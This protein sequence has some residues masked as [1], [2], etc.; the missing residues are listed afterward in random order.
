MCQP[1]FQ[2][3]FRDPI[4]LDALQV[5][6]TRALVLIDTQGQ[7]W[8]LSPTGVSPDHTE[9]A[10]NFEQMVPR[11]TYSI[12][13]GNGS[14]LKDLAGMSPLSSSP[15]AGL[16]GTIQFYEGVTESSDL[17]TLWPSV[18]SALGNSLELAPGESITRTFTSLVSGF[19][20]LKFLG[21]STQFQ[22]DLLDAQG[23]PIAYV[24]EDDTKSTM[25]NE[26]RR[27]YPLEA[28]TYSLILTNK[29][30]DPATLGFAIEMRFRPAASLLDT[31]LGQS[32]STRIRAVS[33][34]SAN[35]DGL[36]ASPSNSTMSD[37]MSSQ[38]TIG[39]AGAT[40]PERSTFFIH[41]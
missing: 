30:T 32:S 15:T 34:I 8:P 5:D 16:L 3:N 40:N 33:I 1:D 14:T 21:N 9:I 12:Q 26:T 24:S 17:G 2:F 11:G 19:E 36:A 4:D 38:L 41:P 20:S 10:F 13:L 7:V 31:G 25:G 29:G 35:G 39:L 23:R 28:G 27:G 37:G 22:I 18:G 6:P